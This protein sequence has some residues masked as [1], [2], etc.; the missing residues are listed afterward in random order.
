MTAANLIFNY[1]NQNNDC[2]ASGHVSA[3]IA[4]SQ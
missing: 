4:L 2:K 1:V 3:P